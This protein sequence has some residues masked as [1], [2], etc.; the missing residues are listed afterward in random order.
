MKYCLNKKHTF[1][2]RNPDFSRWQISFQKHTHTSTV[3]AFMTIV[4][5]CL[6]WK[7]SIQY[8]SLIVVFW[9]RST[10]LQH[11]QQ[12]IRPPQRR[13]VDHALSLLRFGTGDGKSRGIIFSQEEEWKE[14]RRFSMKSLKDLGFGKSSMEDSI[15]GEVEKLIN[16][17]KAKHEGKPVDL[18]GLMNMSIVNALWVLVT[19][20]SL[21]LDDPKLQKIVRPD[22]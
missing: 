16:Q 10:G 22:C 2:K 11:V 7:F 17:L 13:P 18:R 3:Y 19:G 9:A 15:N 12:L 6:L 5:S 8:S 4:S 21:D 20:E 14:Q 1:S